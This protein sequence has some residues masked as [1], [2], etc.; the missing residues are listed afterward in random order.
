MLVMVLWAHPRA[1]TRFSQMLFPALLFSLE[2]VVGGVK[3]EGVGE[4]GVPKMDKGV[5]VSPFPSFNLCLFESEVS[6]DKGSF[7]IP[8]TWAYLSLLYLVANSAN[9]RSG[10]RVSFLKIK[11]KKK[12]KRKKK[13]K[14]SQIYF[15]LPKDL[16]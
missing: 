3:R 9:K 10:R 6:W 7:F 13:G 15:S 11:K 16:L 1:I 12:E 4:D 5:V 2:Q 8:F 14:T